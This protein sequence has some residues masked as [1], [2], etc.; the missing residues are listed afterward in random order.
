[1]S[2]LVQEQNQTTRC[3]QKEQG[4]VQTDN[5]IQRIP[6]IHFSEA[7]ALVQLTQKGSVNK[8][9]KYMNKYLQHSPAKRLNLNPQLLPQPDET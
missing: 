1:M 9:T 8:P 3:N 7:A 4:I 6:L 5:K 2:H